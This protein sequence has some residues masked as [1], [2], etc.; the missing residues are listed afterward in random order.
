[1]CL[2]NAIALL[3]GTYPPGLRKNLVFAIFGAVAP[4]GAVIGA[5]SG[6]IFR[7]NWPWA[8]YSFALVLATAAVVSHFVIPTRVS[9]TVNKKKLSLWQL[10]ET[11]DV[12]GG[13]VGITALTLFNFAWNQ[14]PATSSAVITTLILGICL[15][16]VFFNRDS[17]LIVTTCSLGYH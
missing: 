6:G 15:V 11:L 5:V 12:L 17:G 10:L 13:C 7:K 16:P 9:E 4:G 3:G 8:Y 14:A 1:M 2:P